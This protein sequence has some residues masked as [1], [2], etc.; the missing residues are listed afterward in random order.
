MLS[1]SKLRNYSYGMPG[2]AGWLHARLAPYQLFYDSGPS[3]LNTCHEHY[4]IHFLMEVGLMAI[5]ISSA[6]PHYAVQN[7]SLKEKTILVHNYLF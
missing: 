5:A 2:V 3:V 1:D 4:P 6:I 7:K